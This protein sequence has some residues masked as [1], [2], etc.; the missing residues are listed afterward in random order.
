MLLKSAPKN[1]KSTV[2]LLIYTS[3]AAATSNRAAVSLCGLFDGAQRRASGYPFIDFG[4]DPRNPAVAKVNRLGKF[5]TCHFPHKVDAAIGNA[6][7]GP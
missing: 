4:F 3:F 1:A 2:P 6:L 5:A 7:F